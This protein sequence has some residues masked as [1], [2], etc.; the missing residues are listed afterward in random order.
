[1][2]ENEIAQQVVD[3]AYRIYRALGPGLLESAYQELNNTLAS[4]L[5]ANGATRDK[6]AQYRSFVSA[7]QSDQND[8]A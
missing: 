4:E 7:I 8:S 2:T 3:A 6:F 5:L 1:M